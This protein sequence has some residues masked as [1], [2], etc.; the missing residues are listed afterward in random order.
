MLGEICIDYIIYDLLKCIK[1]DEYKLQDVL[2]WN[3]PKKISNA[4][5]KCPREMPMRNAQ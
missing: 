5:E 3:Q 2:Y 1:L 4:L